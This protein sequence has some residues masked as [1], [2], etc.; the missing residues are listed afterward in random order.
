MGSR[1]GLRGLAHK[2]AL[3]RRDDLFNLSDFDGELVRKNLISA[4]MV[5]PDHKV[6]T[7]AW[8]LL[9]RDGSAVTS[10]RSTTRTNRKARFSHTT[11]FK[12]GQTY[13]PHVME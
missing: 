8:S 10:H 7:L 12:M 5:P 1:T 9:G 6:G 4:D 11:R 3:K 13:F 2:D